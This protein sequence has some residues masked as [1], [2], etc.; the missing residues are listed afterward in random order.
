MLQGRR[1][2]ADIGVR[3]GSGEPEESDG[4]EDTGDYAGSKMVLW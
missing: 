2:P 4:E 1:D 3:A